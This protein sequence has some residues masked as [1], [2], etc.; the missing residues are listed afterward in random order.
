MKEL[1]PNSGIYAVNVPRAAFG[2]EVN[3]KHQIGYWDGE[4][5]QAKWNI[6]TLPPGNY[7]IICTS[8]NA[9]E[10][11]A[12]KVVKSHYSRS[13][14]FNPIVGHYQSTKSQTTYMD[15]ING[16]CTCKTATESLSSLLRSL[17]LTEPN[18]LIIKKEM[19]C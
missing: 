1:I 17:N 9:S 15:Y 4:Q 2:I 16:F 3:K 5:N 11:D 14:S 18:Y 19:V 7:T 8:L 13:A 10:E 12:A 6:K